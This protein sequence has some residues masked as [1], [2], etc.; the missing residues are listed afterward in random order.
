MTNKE[1]FYVIAWGDEFV[2]L[3]Q[4]SGGYPYK[5]PLRGAHQWNDLEECMNYLRMFAKDGTHQGEK[6]EV[7]T[8]SIQLNS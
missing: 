2:E 8:A 4:P 5:R 6:W 1:Y 7:K 3:D